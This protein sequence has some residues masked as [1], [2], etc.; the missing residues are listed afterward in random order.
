LASERRFSGEQNDEIVLKKAEIE[1]LNKIIG[2]KERQIQQVLFPPGIGR[3][4]ET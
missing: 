2:E 4:L 1:R 3:D